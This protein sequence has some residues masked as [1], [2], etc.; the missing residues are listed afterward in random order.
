MARSPSLERVRQLL[1]YEPDTGVWFW[2]Q[3]PGGKPGKVYVAGRRDTGGYRQITIDGAVYQGHRLAFLWMTGAI[4]DLEIDHI[5]GD[6]ANDR[7]SNLRVVTHQQNS[8]NS[9]P[10]RAERKCKGAH[11]HKRD[12]YWFAAISIHGKQKWLGRFPS[13]EAAAAAYDKAAV[14]LFGEFARPNFPTER[15]A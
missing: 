4:P 7:W 14:E 10:K 1:V 12:G 6:R 9:R 3:K 11:F 5:D 13:E 15:A 8:T 2:L